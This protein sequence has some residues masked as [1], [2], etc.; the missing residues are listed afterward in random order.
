MTWIEIIGYCGSGLIAVSL[1][2]KSIKKLRRINLIGAA[3]FATYGLLMEA[4][5]V[6]VLNS[7]ITMVDLYYIYQMRSQKDYFTFL[8]INSTSKYMWKFIEFHAL[9]IKEFFPDFD[10]QVL[11]NNF[12][13]FILRNMLPVGLV[14]YHKLEG[15]SAK[16]DLDFAI[17]DY[18]DLKNSYFLMSC[19]SGFF[20]E[21]GI[22]K[23]LA[24]K[25]T[26]KHNVFL[27]RVGFVTSTDHQLF[28]KNLCP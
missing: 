11:N 9:E 24:E 13:V 19:E 8:E 14:S 26:E 17:P 1:M 16:I 21:R 7:F 22:T 15:S 5:P 18:R 4:Y 10:P 25:T 6:F 27:K 23:L 20:P 3:T 12:S 2:M 28:E